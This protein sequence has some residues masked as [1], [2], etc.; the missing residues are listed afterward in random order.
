MEN[1]FNEITSNFIDH[2]YEVIILLNISNKET[3]QKAI[4]VLLKSSIVISVAYWERFVEDL[5]VYGC[6]FIAKGLRNPQDLPT[7]VK[8]SLA[9]YIVPDKKD[10]N[11]KAF[12][13]SVWSFSGEGWVCQ[14]ISYSNFL[15]KSLNTA[16]TQNVKEL[17]WKVFGIRD[18]FVD[19]IT[20]YPTPEENIDS[21]NSFIKKRHEIAHG[22]ENSMVE[23]DLSKI[24]SYNKLEIELVKHLS[25]QLWTQ[26]AKIVEK[27]AH[28]YNL[29]SEY[30]YQIINYIEVNG[31]APVTNKI[32]QKMSTTANSNYKKLSYQPWRLL[33]TPSPKEIKPTDTLLSFIKG[34]ISLPQQIIVLKNQLAFPKPK[35]KN[36]RYED[37]KTM[38]AK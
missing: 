34:D 15:T 31:F 10:N 8:E 11:K 24:V 2:L 28:V 25:D 1:P 6:K 32:F 12:S 3:D 23:L 17:F 27:S 36:L 33:E 22:S 20:P 16:N 30:I 13:D 37:L 29:N 38:F 14:Y 5:I 19:W 35:T 9:C 18:V 7:I 26:V 21:F 4:N